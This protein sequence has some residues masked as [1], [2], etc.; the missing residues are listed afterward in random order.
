MLWS[1]RSYGQYQSNDTLKAQIMIDIS[2]KRKVH[3]LPAIPTYYLMGKDLT[4]MI[5]AKIRMDC[6]NLQ[7]HF[8][9]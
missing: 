6:S 5:L 2:R 9:L 1:I 3:A 4:E 7:F 8:Y